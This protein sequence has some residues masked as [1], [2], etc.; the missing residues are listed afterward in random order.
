M[1]ESTRPNRAVAHCGRGLWPSGSPLFVNQDV[2]ER[3][4][5]MHLDLTSMEKYLLADGRRT[6]LRFDC[7]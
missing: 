6:K 2:I 5:S 4:L 7:L 1:S 3:H